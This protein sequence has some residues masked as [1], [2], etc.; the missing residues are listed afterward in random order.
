MAKGVDGRDN[1]SGNDKVV[2][3]EVSIGSFTGLGS[4]C[5]NFLIVLCG[6]LCDEIG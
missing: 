2:S 4:H 5:E 1:V 3:E 6:S